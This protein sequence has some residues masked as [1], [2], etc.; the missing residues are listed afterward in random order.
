MPAPAVLCSMGVGAF[1]DVGE[2]QPTALEV[3]Q[4]GCHQSRERVDPTLLF[5]S[6]EHILA[7]DRR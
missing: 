6:G 2:G 3:L 5:E 4:E 7:R 1:G